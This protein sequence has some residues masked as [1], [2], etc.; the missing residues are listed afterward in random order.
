MVLKEILKGNSKEPYIIV[1]TAFSHEGSFEYL[2]QMIDE[3]KYVNNIG[4][5]FQVLIEKDEFLTPANSVYETLDQWLLNAEQWKELI[6]YAEGQN[7]S[8]ILAVLD[9]RGLELAI[10]LC[11]KISA[12]EIHPS[13]IPDAEFMNKAV[14]FCEESDILLILGISGFSFYEIEY[15]IRVYLK[16]FDKDRLL[17][18]Y[19]FQNYP[20]LLTSLHLNRIQ[21]LEE[22]FKMKIA[23]ADHTEYDNELKNYLIALVYGKGINI[24]ELHYVLESGAE[25]TDYITAYDT[26]RI[27]EIRDK[28]LLLNQAL[29]EKTESM[30]EPEKVYSLKFRKI[31]VYGENFPKGHVL[32]LQDIQFKRSN[33]PSQ[34][35]ISEIEGIVGRKLIENV[36]KDQEITSRELK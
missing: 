3:M 6:E 26:K 24:I 13:C 28:L 16:G 9:Q 1:E 11:D 32:K 8:V 29:G 35:L 4:L 27:I 12:I 10:D 7:V 18:M 2:K 14:K 22:K 20:T 31:P 23:Y 5:K 25:R 15:M 34:F 36:I 30:S 21:L 19:G 33:I 17:L